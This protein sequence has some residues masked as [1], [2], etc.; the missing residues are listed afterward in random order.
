MECTISSKNDSGRVR[1]A[2]ARPD[3]L[4]AKLC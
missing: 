4:S 3:A 1:S 2:E